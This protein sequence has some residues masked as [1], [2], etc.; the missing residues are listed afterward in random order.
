[1]VGMSRENEQ[2]SSAA[3][4]FRQPDSALEP[5]EGD[6]FE[7]EAFGLESFE[8]DFEDDNFEFEAFDLAD[9]KDDTAEFDAPEG[10]GAPE[11][12]EV[13]EE[14]ALEEEGSGEVLE[15]EPLEAAAPEEEASFEA[16]GLEALPE[17]DSEAIEAAAPEEA[18]LEEDSGEAFEREHLERDPS[19]EEAPE[20]EAPV[21]DAPQEGLLGE[22]IP[23]EDD[24]NHEAF[25][26]ATPAAPSEP[27]ARGRRRK[28]RHL[29]HPFLTELTRS[30]GSTLTR[31]LAIMGIVGLGVGFFAGLNMTGQDMRGA[32]DAYYDGTHLYDFRV[33]SSMGLTDEQVD[34][35]K[36]L[37]GIDQVAG[38]YATDVMALLNGDR[39]AM[40]IM[41]FDVEAARNATVGEDGT[42]VESAKDSYLNRL[43]LAEGD[44]PSSADECVLDADCV[45]NE[46]IQ[47]GDTVEVLY[48]TGDVDE[49][50]TRRTFTVSGLVH[51]SL[52]P[53]S[54]SL[55]YTSLG[56]GTIQQCV[57]VDEGAFSSDLP[58]TEVFITV[59]GA[60]ELA[61]D[62]DDYQAAVDAVASRID[63]LHLG[64]LRL[65]EV[66]QIA[67]DELAE[68]QAEYDETEAEITA[69]L[70]DAYNELSDAYTQLEDARVALEDGQK[71]YDDG[72][73]QL[74]DA[75]VEADQ[76]LAS[77]RAELEEA[78]RTLNAS[79]A[80]LGMSQA[81]INA[82]SA[83]VQS[84]D[85]AWQPQRSELVSARNDLATI[86]SSMNT[87]S[88]YAASGRALS[89]S[90]LSAISAAANEALAASRRLSSSSFASSLSSAAASE[91]AQL[92]QTLAGTLNSIDFTQSA[93]GIGVQL[94]SSFTST[95]SS[96]NAMA[97]DLISQVDGG[98]AQGDAAIAE[99]RSQVNQAQSARN[100]IDAGWNDLAAGRQT[101][102]SEEA[103]V[104]QELADAQAQLDDAAAQLV[105]ANAEYQDGLA[106]FNEGYATY[107]ENRDEAQSRLADAAKQLQDAREEIEAMGE[108][109]IYVLDRTKN[110]GLVSYLNDSRRIDSIATV[111][112][113]IFFLVA[114]L[115]S[116]TTMTRMVED[117]RIDIGVHRALGFST[118]RITA[119]YV[120]YAGLAGIV[121]SVIGIAALS[122]LLPWVVQVAYHIM[123]A[124]PVPGFPLHIDFGIS[125]VAAGIG[126]GVIFIVI[127]A[128]AA[129]TLREVP[130]TLML[131]RA[132]KAGKRILLE[133]VGIVWKHLSFSWK[134]TFRNLFRYKQRLV[135]TIVG[136][137]G[138]TALLLT[139]FGLHNAIWDIIEYQ[140]KGDN[141]ISRFNLVLGIDEDATDDDYERIEALLKDPGKATGFAYFDLE[142][143]Q[144]ASESHSDTTSVQ[145][146]VVRDC[147][148]FSSM[149]DMRNRLTKEKVAFDTSSVIITE[150]IARVLGI[151]VGDT[152]TVYKQ[153]EIGNATGK[154]YGFTVT[155]ISENYVYHYLFIGADAWRNV[156]G[157]DCAIDSMYAAITSDGE[158]SDR[159]AEGL[160][161][162]DVVSTVGF[163][164]ESID[165][166]SKG[167]RAVDI[168]VVVLVVAAAVLDFIVL[169]NLINIQLIERTREIASLKVLGFNRREVGNYLLRETIILVFVGALVGLAL[170]VVMEGFVVVTA[171]VDAVMFGRD[172]H[173]MSYLYSFGLSIAFSLI[174]MV[175]IAPKL[176]GIDMVES[177]KSVD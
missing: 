128:A 168:I 36:E 160:A 73:A 82:A 84:A 97:S 95:V 76:Q 133:R 124:I 171:E 107:I 116:L 77:A 144:V 105:D 47:I 53:S 159:L 40:R 85:A 113:A 90:D 45:M 62:S 1:M 25:D 110:V 123:Y 141:P 148:A 96:A 61:S 130:A 165:S 175:F 33:L 125:L 14:A 151:G 38:G 67:S 140:D 129:A 153:D 80:Q 170:G 55:G 59:E 157:K 8:D 122:Q 48:G 120:A 176:R 17:E 137:A 134:V 5:F 174:V 149:V 167:L 136:V 74:A 78:E 60:A 31:F 34:A 39:Y 166:Y 3:K 87:L 106:Q 118:A 138:C 12:E 161:G 32:A 69:E 139:G 21:W 86:Q 72:V 177:L 131:P 119:K 58:Y 66:K 155:G 169:Y 115:V 64:A 92:S 49:M 114:A 111:F 108:P 26:P 121:G 93:E 127:F 16:E 81:D 28:V 6:S 50:L 117:E 79:E 102:A 132:P 162:I 18:A 51:A 54:I 126:L 63:D 42:T 22:E 145:V 44:W 135:M 101:Y 41:S 99:A 15:H 142:N 29:R 65:D 152:V 71:E 158:A 27:A 100:Q 109:S 146:S 150:K 88:S 4:H 103:R 19:E 156:M 94:G 24:L 13:P 112:P 10:E 70:T 173:L 2:G 172:I 143:M 98:I 52:F 89:A 11:D 20:G 9:L 104:T 163:S 23:G 91:A 7:D 75:R 147:E 35:L 46:P 164:Q 83:S 30:I 57:F 37:D 154:G 68:A 56:S 43:I